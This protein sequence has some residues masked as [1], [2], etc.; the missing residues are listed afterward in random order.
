M[1]PELSELATKAAATMIQLL[2]TEAWEQA[3]SVAG[4][5]WR[6]ARPERAERIEAD[7]ADAHDDLLAAGPDS[8]TA[9]ELAAQWES[10]LRTLLA[11]DPALGPLLR[12][13]L[14]QELTPALPATGSPQPSVTTTA[15]ARDHGQAIAAG[16]DVIIN[17]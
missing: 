15:N 14:D 7:I 8:D 1:D 11:A 9:T 13:L 17:K 5:L 6:R 3:K 12:R 10:K 4:K 16:R 2:A